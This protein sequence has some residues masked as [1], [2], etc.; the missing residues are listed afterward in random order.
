MA[1]NEDWITMNG[2]HILVDKDNKEA[3]IEK[4]LNKHGKTLKKIYEKAK[5]EALKTDKNNGFQVL[6]NGKPWQVQKTEAGTVL[7]NGKYVKGANYEKLLE[8]AKK[9]P[10]FA[11]L[12]ADYFAQ[13]Q[14]DYMKRRSEGD[15]ELGIGIDIKS[16]GKR[17]GRKI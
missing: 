3:S 5:D 14:A 4:F 15:N 10:S 17:V 8:N 9:D 11:E 1:K 6:M 12:S 7:I 16:K 2:T 13:K